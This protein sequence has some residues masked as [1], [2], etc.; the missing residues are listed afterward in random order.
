MTTLDLVMV[1][2]PAVLIVIGIIVAIIGEY[3]E[4][5]A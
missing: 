4:G 3:V 5:C 1:A 2:A